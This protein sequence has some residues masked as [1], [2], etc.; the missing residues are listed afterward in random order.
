MSG[1]SNLSL[2]E[3][4]NLNTRKVDGRP[5]KYTEVGAFRVVPDA[6]SANWNPA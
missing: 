5:R 2:A 4:V 3:S 1:A 6:T